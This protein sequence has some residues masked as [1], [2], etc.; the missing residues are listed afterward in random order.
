MVEFVAFVFGVVGLV[1]ILGIEFGMVEFLQTLGVELRV[2]RYVQAL[3]L[4]LF[5]V[6]GVGRQP[7]GRA[8]FFPVVRLRVVQFLGGV[9]VLQR[10]ARFRVGLLLL[11][12]RRGEAPGLHL[13]L[14]GLPGPL[15]QVRERG[16]GDFDR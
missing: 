13:V 2:V 16:L 12:V 11:R 1:E 3:G 15:R 10:A 5:R 9:A 8:V 14:P 7:T 4:G 6:F